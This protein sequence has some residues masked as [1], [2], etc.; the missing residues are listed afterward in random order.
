[1]E[2]IVDQFGMFVRKHQGRLRVH[3]DK[4][5]VQEVPLLHLEQVLIIGGGIGISSDAIRAC[6]EQGTPIHFLSSR[7]PAEA[8]LYSAG[9]TGTVRTRRAQLRAYDDERGV[10]LALA[11]AG[12]KLRSQAN[13]LR[14]AGKYRR[15]AAPLIH[16]ELALLAQEVMDHERD[17]LGITGRCIDDVRDVILSIEARGAQRYWTGIKLLVP[18]ALGWPGREGRG[19]LDPFNAA[20]NYG[21]GIL[22]AHVERALVVAGLDPYGGF[23]HADRPGKAS[24]IFDVI[25]EFRQ[26][27]VDRTLLGLVN[28]GFAIKRDD[29]GRLE[30]E[31][32]HKLAEKLKERLDATELYEGKRQPLRIV[33]QS[34]A[35]HIATFL[36]GDRAE[37]Q[38]FAMGW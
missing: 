23:L 29:T 13:L 34:Q 16:M 1:M 4:E 26:P 33:L 19:A 37:Y 9:L 20:L 14:Y 24:L 17:L 5:V 25:E 3:R 21:Y 11:F 6:C 12:G 38:P 31:T 18:E 15:E 7:G 35:R 32:R 36:R 22:A 2:L 28:R 27:V 8:S 10:G 30:S